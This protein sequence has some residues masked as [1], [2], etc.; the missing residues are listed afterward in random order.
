MRQRGVDL[1][2]STLHSSFC[3]SDT[4]PEHLKAAQEGVIH[5]CRRRIRHNRADVQ[6][7]LP[8][9]VN[10]AWC[11]VSQVS[12][13]VMSGADTT[14]HIGSGPPTEALTSRAVTH[15]SEPPEWDERRCASC[16]AAMSCVRASFGS[17]ASAR[18]SVRCHVDMG[19]GTVGQQLHSDAQLHEQHLKRAVQLEAVILAL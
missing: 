1:A 3:T 8:V 5:Y 14:V 6:Q 12:M 18:C 2:D 19:T 15:S 16:S 4:W 11:G 13:Y 9:L 7:V 10:A 17:R